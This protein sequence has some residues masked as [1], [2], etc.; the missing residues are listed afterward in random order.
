MG[1]SEDKELDFQER[2]SYLIQA[3]EGYWLFIIVVAN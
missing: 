3:L 2:L 1:L